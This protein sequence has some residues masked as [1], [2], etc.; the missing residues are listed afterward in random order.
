MIINNHQII[1]PSIQSLLD[2]IY[3]I[4]CNIVYKFYICYIDVCVCKY[5]I[6]GYFFLCFPEI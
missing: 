5:K 1:H 3:I 2:I 6:P 4:Q